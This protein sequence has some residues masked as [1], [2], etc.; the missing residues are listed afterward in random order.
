MAYMQP[1]KML[2]NDFCRPKQAAHKQLT[3][4]RDFSGLCRF[5]GVKGMF[6]SESSPLLEH[7]EV[8]QAQA[9]ARRPHGSHALEL[10]E[11]AQDLNPVIDMV[12]S[13]PDSEKI[14]SVK[15]E[16]KAVYGC[17]NAKRWGKLVSEQKNPPFPFPFSLLPSRS[18]YR[19]RSE[20]RAPTTTPAARRRPP[21]PAAPPS[22]ATA[23]STG[24]W[25]PDAVHDEGLS[26]SL[27]TTKV[28]FFQIWW[29]GVFPS[30]ATILCYQSIRRSLY[31]VRFASDSFLPLSTL[32]IGADPASL[33]LTESRP[34]KREGKLVVLDFVGF[35]FVFCLV[36]VSS[37]MGNLSP[38]FGSF[39]RLVSLVRAMSRSGFPRSGGCWYWMCSKFRS[40]IQCSL[41]LAFVV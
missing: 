23:T 17:G 32:L 31:S 6:C 11:A 41:S 21:T 2:V 1:M 26:L 18:K 7:F 22:P 15:I 5:L 10:F 20:G 30:E 14:D 29:L 37:L 28:T 12:D 13:H 19:H 25:H 34:N 36:L 35:V 33:G 27:S 9:F 4:K 38:M 16:V 8:A 3:Q 40:G 39:S 24:F